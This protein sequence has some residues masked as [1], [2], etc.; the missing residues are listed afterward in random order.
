MTESQPENQRVESPPEQR[1]RTWLPLAV[2]AGLVLAVVIVGLLLNG[3]PKSTLNVT[4]VNAS[5]DPYA[6]KLPMTD[7]AMS[8]SS[9]L[10]GGKVTYLDG[11]IANRG[12]DVVM[13]ITVQVLFRNAAHEVAQNETMPMSLVRMR[14]PYIDT[15]PV[16]VAPLKAGAE[17]DFRLNFDTVSPDWDGTM[18]EVR[19]V[20]VSQHVSQRGEEK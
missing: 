5:L 1:E 15:E 18:P 2:A 13:G 6:D 14:E 8:E 9:N 17:Q 12:A 10:A 4:P 11:H 3:R 19:V 7:L 16:A 20:H